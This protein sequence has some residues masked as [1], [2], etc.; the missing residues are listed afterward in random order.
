MTPGAYS[1]VGGKFQGIK[2]E[3]MSLKN[4]ILFQFSSDQRLN[5]NKL[6]CFFA[7]FS[8]QYCSIFAIPLSIPSA[9]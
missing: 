7:I 5:S 6:S 9:P 3:K 1:T 4:V 2:T 8:S